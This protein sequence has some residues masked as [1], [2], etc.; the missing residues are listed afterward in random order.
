MKEIKKNNNKFNANLKK[1][2]WQAITTLRNNKDIVI[3]QADKGGNIVIK[4]KHDDL[5]EGL[6]QLSNNNH[7]ELLEEDSTQGYNNHIHQVLQQAT[8]LMTKNIF[9]NLFLWISY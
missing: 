3:K 7:Y 8:N 6:R 5:Q 1:E 4:D 2:E 9:K